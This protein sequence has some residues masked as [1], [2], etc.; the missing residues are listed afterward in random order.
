MS[1]FDLRES[2]LVMCAPTRKFD[3][4]NDSSVPQSNSGSLC[5]FCHCINS[6]LIVVRVINESIFK[7]ENKNSLQVQCVR[8]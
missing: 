7:C 1:F 5:V 2:K 8:M 3:E 6:N 4:L